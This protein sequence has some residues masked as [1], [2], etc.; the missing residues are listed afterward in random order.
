MGIIAWYAATTP[1]DGWLECNGQ[2]TVGYPELAAIVGGTVP[3]LRGQFIRG[4]VNDK[5]GIAN[6]SGVRLFGSTQSSSN[7]RHWHGTGNTYVDDGHTMLRRSW[8][9][10]SN[11]TSGSQSGDGPNA[12]QG[13]WT[14]A[15]GNLGSTWDI[16]DTGNT[17][18]RP[19]NISLLPCIKY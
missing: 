3:D 4:W 14:L 13:S 5:G 7:L 11:G 9:M 17:E 1:P 12:Y 16:E 19:M 10:A 8:V 6:E 15:S 2:S 18:S